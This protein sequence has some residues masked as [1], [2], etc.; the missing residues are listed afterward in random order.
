MLEINLNLLTGTLLEWSFPLIG[1]SSGQFQ[2]GISASDPDEA[3]YHLVDNSTININISKNST[4]D[5]PVSSRLLISP[6][7][8][9]HNGTEITCVDMSSSPVMESSKTIVVIGQV[10]G[11]HI[12]IQT[13][14]I[15]IVIIDKC[16]HS[17]Y[18]FP[19]CKSVK[20]I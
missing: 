3:K 9:S 17:M 2:Y 6:V 8:E 10:Q 1:S 16:M 11:T 13:F 5:S 4:E 14:F 7:T 15:D 18:R 12:A 20:D 19:R